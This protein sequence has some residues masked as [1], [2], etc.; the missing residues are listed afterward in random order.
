MASR[1]IRLEVDPPLAEALERLSTVADDES[2]VIRWAVLTLARRSPPA[3]R[4]DEDDEDV[5][6]LA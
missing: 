5:R 3:A 4:R 1:F 6:G 2:E